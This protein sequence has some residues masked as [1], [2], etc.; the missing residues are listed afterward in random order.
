M[1]KSRKKKSEKK[2][3]KK[4]KLR[5]G[6]KVSKSKETKLSFVAKKICL[7]EETDKE[8]RSEGSSSVLYLSVSL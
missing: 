4:V 1:A 7:R 2:D 6:R 3:F 5:V 8:E